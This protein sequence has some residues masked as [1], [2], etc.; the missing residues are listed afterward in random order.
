MT[1]L[2]S[3]NHEKCKTCGLVMRLLLLTLRNK[4]VASELA[5][6][7][8]KLRLTISLK[9]QDLL[10]KWGGFVYVFFS[11]S[12][13]L[14]LSVVGWLQQW[15]KVTKVLCLDFCKAFDKNTFNILAFKLESG[16]FDGWIYSINKELAG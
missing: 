1:P 15:T 10:W 9:E 6:R 13:E 12:K 7:M 8:E 4:S 14:G 3:H 2:N 5:E 11:K 16:G